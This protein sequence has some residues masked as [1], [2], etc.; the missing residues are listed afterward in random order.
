[1]GAMKVSIQDMDKVEHH[2][3]GTQGFKPAQIGQ[4]KVSATR[5]DMIAI[6]PQMSVE[7]CTAKHEKNTESVM[8][9]DA[10]FCCVDSMEARM[11]L[12]CDDEFFPRVAIDTRMSAMSMQVFY[13][14]LKSRHEY[15]RTIFPDSEAFQARCT[16]KSTIF[17]A[18]TAASLAVSMWTQGLHGQPP[19]P[20]AHLSLTDWTLQAFPLPDDEGAAEVQPPDAAAVQSG[21]QA[22]R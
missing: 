21:P 19:L 5:D 17:T 11:S 13:V 18:S 14:D 3:M 22:E 9:Y 6:N 2:N 10:V 16:A 12:L 4:Y 20:F 1:M 8:G 15:K 7:T